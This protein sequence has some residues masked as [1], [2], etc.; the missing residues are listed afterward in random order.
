MATR[1][2]LLATFPAATGLSITGCLSSPDGDGGPGI[3]LESVDD[4]PDGPL[5]I[6][7]AVTRE[8]ATEERPP[9]LRVSVT[10][11]GNETVDVGEARAVVFA[12]RYSENGTLM[13]LPDG[14]DYP[15]EPGCW[16]L[17]EGI[18]VSEEYRIRTLAPG[19]SMTSA[20]SLYATTEVPENDCLPT[21][22]HRFESRYTLNPVDGDQQFRW[23][24]TVALE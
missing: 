17:T 24:F 13:L 20:L 3:R 9:G 8:A 10:N 11:T 12:Y 18:G 2:S 1:R 14:G 19:E 23:G 7:V 6:E 5:A 22:E 16:R 15:A 21:G 4:Q